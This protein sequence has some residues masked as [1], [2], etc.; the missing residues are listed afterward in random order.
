MIAIFC[1]NSTQKFYVSPS[2]HI[3]L[4]ICSAFLASPWLTL[5]LFQGSFTLVIQ[6]SV[7]SN[8]PQPHSFNSEM[9]GVPLALMWANLNNLQSSVYF[10]F[11][12]SADVIS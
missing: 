4:S 9:T 12:P 5:H 7:L 2:V 1:K 6:S 3:Q 11:Q 8:Q 10:N